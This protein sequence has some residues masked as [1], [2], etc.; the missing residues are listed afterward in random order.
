MDEGK[1][2]MVMT[3]ISGQNSVLLAIVG[4][5]VLAGA[6]FIFV[7]VL[8]AELTPLQVVA[9][10]TVA[11]SV[12]VSAVMLL[13]RTRMP[14]SAAF[15]RGVLILGVL[16]GVAP[17]LLVANAQMHVSSATAAI[18]VSTM[19][20]F[21]TL[22]AWWSLQD[23]S[24]G[25]ATVAGI[26][27]GF[28]GV[29]ILAGPGALDVS[30]DTAATGGLLLAAASYAAATVYAKGLLKIATPLALTG[31]KLTIAAAIVAPLALVIDGT[32]NFGAMSNEGWA[33]LVTLGFGSTGLGRAVYVWAIGKAGSVKASLVTY[34]APIVAIALGWAVLGE[35]VDVR[36][37]G[38]GALI[39]AG[40]AAAMFGRQ[41][42][43]MIRRIF[44]GR[45]RQW[46]N[47]EAGSAE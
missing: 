22:F 24:L 5:G 29:I 1:C 43:A 8:V 34:I 4:F 37:L 44:E 7:K 31:A 16:D 20:L 27:A 26:A 30:N 10:R 33:S 45:S 14:I 21:T 46:A 28:A 13:T 35:T 38:G 6:A 2:E 36:M 15:V 3:R 17:Y 40:V 25:P 12:A 9:S 19:P 47:L 39:V 32:A 11:G 41:A 42:D 23:H 18:L